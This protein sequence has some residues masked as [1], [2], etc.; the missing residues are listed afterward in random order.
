MN[1]IVCAFLVCTSLIGGFCEASDQRR[2]N[3]VF[4][5]TDDQRFDSLGS[6]GN[7]IIKTPN[8]DRL[9][10]SGVLFT[11]HFVTTPICSVSRA[12]IFS[13][14]HLRR[15]QIADFAT[16]FSLQ[17]WEK[18]YP[19]LLRKNGYRTGFI[20]KFGVGNAQAIAAMKDSFDYWHGL[21]GQ[22]GQ[23]FIDPKNPSGRHATARFGDRA[24]EFLDGSSN[25]QPFCLSISFNAP[26]A[27]DREK[28]EF[29]PDRRDEKLY[30]DVEIPQPA[31]ATTSHF[32]EMPEFVKTSEARKR[33][34]KRFATPEMFQSTMKDY[35]RLV[36]GIDRE[37]G[38]IVE[39]LEARGLAESTI[40]I[41]TS[42]NGWFAGE[43]GL[44][45]K[46]FVYEESIRV[47]MIVYDPRLP[48]E[49][50][51]RLVEAMTLNIDLGPTMLTMAGVTVPKDMQ[52]RSLEG[53][54]T[55]EM[56]ADWRKAFYFEHNYGPQIIPPSEGV[57]TE[58]WSYV[59]WMPPNV[60]S[61]ELYDLQNDRWQERNL[62][63][64]PAHA[65]KLEELR[66]EL[67]RLREDAR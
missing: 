26:H 15:H 63:G 40:I 49:K 1:Q 14:Q 29:E 54:I 12:S 17:Q 34:E 36:T 2:P 47:P 5:L 9:A 64:D 32:E 20:G 50:R 57:R 31:T 44:A 62:A 35:Y 3:F 45:D 67:E 24:L 52:G 58:R 19:A 55:G 48:K 43:R 6:V 66:V 41:F 22:A 33:W 7:S 38:R 23:W 21:P 61:E 16:P 39:R 51:G 8:I 53:W 4:V 10:K 18:T 11:N 30:R 56:V 42:D 13:G 59:R 37:M 25:A 28:R 46:W 60:E 27:R 65:E